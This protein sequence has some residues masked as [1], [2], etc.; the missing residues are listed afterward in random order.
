MQP[1]MVEADDVND[2]MSMTSRVEKRDHSI[3]RSISNIPVTIADPC[4]AGNANIYF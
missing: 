4:L 3:A 1:D 2:A